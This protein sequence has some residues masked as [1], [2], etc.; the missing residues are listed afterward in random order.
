L[1]V[2]RNPLRPGRERRSQRRVTRTRSHGN[3]E[4][5][6]SHAAQ[7]DEA[8]TN[9][10]ILFGE[11]IAAV[12]VLTLV[13]AGLVVTALVVGLCAHGLLLDLIGS[14]RDRGRG[15]PLFVSTLTILVLTLLVLTLL[16]FDRAGRRRRCGRR[17]RRGV[18]RTT[19]KRHRHAGASQK[20]DSNKG[21]DQL[22]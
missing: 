6:G 4:R 12:V 2:S 8:L 3:R 14:L 22:A 15:I 17:Q 7:R 5:Q 1:R 18:C 10:E 9:S 20:S 21:Y 16:V 13:V 11:L 19:R